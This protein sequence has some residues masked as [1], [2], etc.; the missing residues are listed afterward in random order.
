MREKGAELLA[1]AAKLEGVVAE[2]AQALAAEVAGLDAKPLR[3]VPKVELRQAL[4]ALQQ[5]VDHARRAGQ[6]HGRQVEVAVE[7]SRCAA[8]EA[9]AEAAATAAEAEVRSALHDAAIAAGIESESRAAELVASAVE[10]AAAAVREALRVVKDVRAQGEARAPETRFV[11]DRMQ[12]DLSA[13]LHAQERLLL[14]KA[15]EAQAAIAAQQVRAKVAAVADTL[16]AIEAALAASDVLGLAN[17]AVQRAKALAAARVEKRDALATLLRAQARAAEQ[18]LADFVQAKLGTEGA[19][20]AGALAD[21]AR[22]QGVELSEDQAAFVTDFFDVSG[23]GELAVASIATLAAKVF[24]CVN[25]IAMTTQQELGQGKIIH[26]LEEGHL[27]EAL[28]E[29]VED[30]SSKVLRVRV[31]ILTDRTITGWTS[32]RGNHGTPFLEELS[33]ESLRLYVKERDG[34]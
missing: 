21:F 26:S 5:R 3:K 7:R 30:G 1:A 4:V 20:T 12:Q 14:S 2:A 18:S 24:K 13:F 23:S 25:K 27:V 34:H 29:P 33:R 11:L 32:L 6:E 22:A 16:Q 28:E 15:E 8:L 9:L 31:C 19:V 10:V 17:T